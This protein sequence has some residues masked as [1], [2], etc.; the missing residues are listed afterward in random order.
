MFGHLTTSLAFVRRSSEPQSLD[1]FMLIALRELQ[2]LGPAPPHDYVLH[3]SP[4][5]VPRDE[6]GEC[7]STV[8]HAQEVAI[9]CDFKESSQT[10]TNMPNRVEKGKERNV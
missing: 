6:M 10:H 2:R 4:L 3:P 8:T 5:H 9:P 1:G 7:I